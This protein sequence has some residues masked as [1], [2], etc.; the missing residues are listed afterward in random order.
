V[1]LRA[2][3][4]N[5]FF[6]P[7]HPAVLLGVLFFAGII[8]LMR[9]TR[10]KNNLIF[11]STGWFML[12]LLP[13][14]NIIPI[15]QAYYMSEH[16]LYLPSVG[17]C[18]LLAYFLTRLINAKRALGL[19][20]VV[21]LLCVYSCLTV[22]QNY[23]W[24]DDITFYSRTIRYNPDNPR[25]HYNLAVAL[26]SRGREEEAIEAYKNCLKVDQ[27]YALAHHNLAL[28]YSQR[29]QFDLADQHKNALSQLGV[30]GS[31]GEL[32]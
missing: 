5:T 30:P 19:V 18:I 27:D 6:N 25:M 16:W 32:K 2:D 7:F 13:V 1:A 29:K 28:L 9:R 15:N 4:G 17:F 8:I 10:N 12:C 26:R 23:Y 21:I 20:C 24:L 22:L 14:T 31:I 3:Y 11:F